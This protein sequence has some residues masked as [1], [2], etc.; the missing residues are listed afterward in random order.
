MWSVEKLMKLDDSII[1]NCPESVYCPSDDTFLLIDALEVTP[2]EHALEVGCGSGLV[3]LHLAKAGAV[4]TA[5]DLN[6]EAAICAKAAA[7]LNGLRLEVIRSDLFQNVNG[8][9]DLIVFN[10]P[11]LRGEGRDVSDLAWAGGRTGTETLGR[12]LEQSPA[13]LNAGGRI[14]VIVSSDMEKIPLKEM[15]DPFLVKELRAQHLFFEELRVL[16][17][18][19]REIIMS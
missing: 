13:H 7:D 11:Y 16:E 4:V 5:V 17:L 2:G 3:S 14:L 18:R 1:V 6:N 10:P 9:F 19:P 15:L 8:C 12:F